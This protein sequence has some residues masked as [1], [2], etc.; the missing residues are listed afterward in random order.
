M[1][2]LTSIVAVNSEGAIGCRNGLPWR[3][4]SD[5]LFFKEQTRGQVVIMG[6]KTFD[7]L[8]RPLSDRH[9]IVLSHNNV[10]FEKSENSEVVTSISEALVVAGK[11]RERETFVMGGAL[12]Y[13]Q[14]A[15]YVDRYLVT[16]VDKRVPDADAFFDQGVFCDQG[17]WQLTDLGG[18]DATS[19]YDEAIFKIFEVVRIDP[20]ESIFARREKISEYRTKMLNR[21]ARLRDRSLNKLGHSSLE[22]QYR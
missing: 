7:S 12:T 22:F 1:K 14:F 20:S 18:I 21:P 10:L 5:L 16:M 8:G 4:R 2:R 13:S 3:L 6:R 15:P 9:N 11:R 17:K 19:E